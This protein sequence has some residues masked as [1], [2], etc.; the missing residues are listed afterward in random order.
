[1]VTNAYLEELICIESQSTD[2]AGSA[3]NVDARKLSCLTSP[4][5][6]HGNASVSVETYIHCRAQLQQTAIQ[7]ICLVEHAINM[8]FSSH[9]LEHGSGI[10]H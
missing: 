9:V 4:D 8:H 1:M 2:R 3:R 5:M 10:S 7:D 6:A